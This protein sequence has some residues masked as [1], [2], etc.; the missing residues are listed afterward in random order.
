MSVEHNLLASAANAPRRAPALGAVDHRGW[1]ARVAA[2]FERLGVGLD[3]Q[4]VVGRLGPAER[5]FVE[6]VRAMLVEPRFLILD[7][8]TASLEP[9]AARRVLDLMTTLR[10]HGVGLAFVSHR[11]DEV[12][13]IAD[14]VT[15]LRDGTRVTE[16][17]APGLST[18]EMAR[19]MVGDRPQESVRRASRGPEQEVLLRLREVRVT[20]DGEC[21]D[22]DVRRGETVAVTGLVGSGAAAFV[23]MVGGAEPLRGQAEID[24]REVPWRTPRDAQEHGVG[25]IPEDRKTRGLVLEHSSAVNVS[26]ASLRSVSRAGIVSRRRL[27]A[28]AEDYRRRLDVRTT[29]ME[30]PVASLS[31]GNQQKVMV[32]KWLAAGVRLIA[33]EEPTQGVDIAGRAQ[34]H[35][36]FRDFTAAGGA[37]VLFSTDVREVLGLAD[38]V[39]VFRHGRLHDVHPAGELDETQLTALTAGE[40]RSAWAQASPDPRPGHALHPAAIGLLGDPR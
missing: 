25:F 19:L 15:V 10:D 11:L 31:G 35:E 18:T 2:L 26:L 13:A 24:G 38:R 6:I 12:Q 3:P 30:A 22:L 36:L 23:A 39:A 32:A 8:P 40:Q 5:K 27:L 29:S 34:I 4:A 28:R 33:V 14:R 20:D 1:R 7:E 21:F 17:A 37:V 9:A 16:R